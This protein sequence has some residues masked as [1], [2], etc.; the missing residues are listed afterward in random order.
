M[1][2]ANSEKPWADGKEFTDADKDSRREGE[3]GQGREGHMRSARE[4]GLQSRADGESLIGFPGVRCG[5]TY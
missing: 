2:G 1:V 4:S 3:E 5:E